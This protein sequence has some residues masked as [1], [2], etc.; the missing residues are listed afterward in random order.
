M[1]CPLPQVPLLLQFQLRL[2][3]HAVYAV[4]LVA[5]PC[6]LEWFVA[7]LTNAARCGVNGDDRPVLC[8]PA[9]LPLGTAPDPSHSWQTKEIGLGG[10]H[11]SETAAA[12]GGFETVEVARTAAR[13][14][15]V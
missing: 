1:S 4:V 11:T 7:V 10:K 12:D 15:Q 2:H 3:S 14:G 9:P 5:S 13:L 6:A 8:T